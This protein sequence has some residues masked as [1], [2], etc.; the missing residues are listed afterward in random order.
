M[1]LMVI[2]HPYYQTEAKLIYDSGQQ[3]KQDGA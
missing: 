3:I 2:L 1:N